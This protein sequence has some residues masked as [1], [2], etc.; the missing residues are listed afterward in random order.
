MGGDATAEA[1]GSVVSAVRAQKKRGLAVRAFFAITVMQILVVG[2]S[3]E[4][5]SYDIRMDLV[6]CQPD[7]VI[8]KFQAR[9][10]PLNYWIEQTVALEGVLEIYDIERPD[11]ICPYRASNRIQLEECQGYVNNYIMS[12]KKC[13]SYS[14]RILELYRIDKQ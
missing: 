6:Y 4:A 5:W 2:T 8:G 11:K 3:A 12:I 9:Y 7:G 10:D 14:N 1:P 13:L